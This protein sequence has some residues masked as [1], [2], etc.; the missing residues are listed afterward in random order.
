MKIF[1]AAA[2]FVLSHTTAQAFEIQGLPPQFDAQKWQALVDQAAKSPDVMDSQ[3][4]Q[5]RILTRMTPNDPTQVHQADYFSVI[6]YPTTDGSSFSVMSVS[7]VSETWD[8]DADGN[9]DVDQWIYRLSAEGELTGISHN[10]LVETQDGYV[11]RYDSFPTKGPEDA[12]ELAH[13][14]LKLEE[15]LTTPASL[16]LH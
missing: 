6:G 11:L 15:W 7:A 2:L 14:G 13:W 4:G 12:G 8:I 3:M 9:W 10:R 5:F 1:I 16:H